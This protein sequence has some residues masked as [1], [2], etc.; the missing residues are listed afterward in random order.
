MIFFFKKEEKGGERMKQ[1]LKNKA[2]LF[3]YLMYAYSYE[4]ENVETKKGIQK[5]LKDNELE[6]ELKKL[7]KEKV[8]VENLL[9]ELKLGPHY[10]RTPNVWLQIYSKENRSGARGRYVGISFSKENN[11]VELWIRFW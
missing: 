8:K 3:D 4:L 2:E 5:R 11:E 7:V 1:P 6:E 9:V 10:N